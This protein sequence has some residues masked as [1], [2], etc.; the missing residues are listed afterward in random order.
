[1]FMFPCF[2]YQSETRSMP[3]G[4]TSTQSWM[5]S[6]RKRIVSAS[7][8]L[9][10]LPH[11]LQKLLGAEGLGGMQAAVDPHHGLALAWRGPSLCRR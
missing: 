6:S 9:D 5:T 8:R 2:M 7:V 10:H 1:M 4:L 11:V 3:S